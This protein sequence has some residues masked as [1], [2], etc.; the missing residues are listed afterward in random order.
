[1]TFKTP[2]DTLE[3]Q[4]D[5]TYVFLRDGRP[6]HCYR[7]VGRQ[8]NSRCASFKGP[9]D[10]EM[11]FP[12]RGSWSA[13]WFIGCVA[14]SYNNFQGTVHLRGDPNEAADLPKA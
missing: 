12:D 5:G 9:I 1:M 14:T 10:R 13:K 7:N 11:D 2:V 8:C 6:V 4:P 3:Q